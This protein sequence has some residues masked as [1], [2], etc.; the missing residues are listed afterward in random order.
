ML[1]IECTL[2]ITALPQ[3][4][5]KIWEDVKNWNTWDAGL[6]FSLIDGPFQTGTTGKLKPKRGPLVRTKLIK[7]DPMKMFVDEALLPGTKIIISHLM[8]RR[9]DKTY[10][11]HRIEM[12][13]ALSW[14]FAFLI[15]DVG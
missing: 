3:Q 4:V 1:L 2:D 10:A 11:T 5:W 12:K 14:L 8:R 6:E 9:G 15:E 7:V 13:G